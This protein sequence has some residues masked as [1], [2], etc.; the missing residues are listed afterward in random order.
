MD[1]DRVGQGWQRLDLHSDGDGRQDERQGD[2]QPQECATRTR[3]RG[4][5]VGHEVSSSDGR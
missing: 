5:V 2:T 3:E 1:R 4:G